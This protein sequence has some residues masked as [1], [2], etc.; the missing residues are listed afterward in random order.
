MI[1]CSAPNVYQ[2]FIKR[3]M[4][5]N[6]LSALEWIFDDSVVRGI[7]LHYLVGNWSDNAASF[8]A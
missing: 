3:G 4:V 7:G 5:E 6:T 8:T 2:G 1:A